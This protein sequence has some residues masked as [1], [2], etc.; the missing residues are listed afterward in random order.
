MCTYIYTERALK[1]SRKYTL[2]KVNFP[3]EAGGCFGSSLLATH[4]RPNCDPSVRNSFPRHVSYMV[5]GL[6]WAPLDVWDTTTQGL[7]E[8]LGNYEGI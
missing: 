2:L 5:M 8:V 6:L 1:M 7:V 4:V 3:H